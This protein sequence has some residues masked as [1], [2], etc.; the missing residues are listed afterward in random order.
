MKYQAIIVEFVT[1]QSVI[2]E[3]DRNGASCNSDITCSEFAG[4][5]AL[6]ALSMKSRVIWDVRPWS[7]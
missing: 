4:F 3:R 7:L 2:M 6:K 5:E 1:L